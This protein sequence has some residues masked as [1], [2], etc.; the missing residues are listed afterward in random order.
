MSQAQAQR[1]LCRRVR[2]VKVPAAVS[3][4]TLAK[5]GTCIHGA[6]RLIASMFITIIHISILPPSRCTP[7]LSFSFFSA[8]P[9]RGLRHTAFGPFSLNFHFLLTSQSR[10]SK[11]LPTPPQ[12]P[13]STRNGLLY[14]VLWAPPGKHSVLL[15]LVTQFVLNPHPFLKKPQQTTLPPIFKFVQEEL[16]LPCPPRV[17][18]YANLKESEREWCIMQRQ[19]GI[20]LPVAATTPINN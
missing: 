19:Y 20:Q 13:I 17:T 12:S 18:A 6:S 3:S 14:A 9:S 7:P 2:T 10:W 8:R 5:R 15:Q 11:S 1:L 4:L 16:S